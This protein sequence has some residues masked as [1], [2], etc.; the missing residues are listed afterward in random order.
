MLL[1]RLGRPSPLLLLLWLL[2]RGRLRLRLLSRLRS[3]GG[4]AADSAVPGL[5]GR[6]PARAGAGGGR[7]RPAAH[8]VDLHVPVGAVYLLVAK[9]GVRRDDVLRASSVRRSEIAR[10]RG[11]PRHGS[12]RGDSRDSREQC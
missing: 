8:V 5:R 2:L 9:V 7:G 10:E 3:G 1:R 4:A 6:V 11:L 12:G